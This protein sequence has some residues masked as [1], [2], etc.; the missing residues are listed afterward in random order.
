VLRTLL[1]C[2]LLQFIA[3]VTENCHFRLFTSLLQSLLIPNMQSTYGEIA[4]IVKRLILGLYEKVFS[5]MTSLCTCNS[6]TDFVH[7]L[8]LLSLFLK[9][10][11]SRLMR[12]PCCLCPY[13]YP[14]PSQQLL[15]SW[16][17]LNET[18]H[19][20]HGTW[21]HL[22]R[23]TSQIHS[24][25]NINIAASHNVELTLIL[26]D[27]LNRSLWNLECTSCY[28]RSSQWRTSQIHP[29]SK[30]NTADSHTK[31]LLAYDHPH[32]PKVHPFR[33]DNALATTLPFEI[34]LIHAQLRF[35]KNWVY[36]IVSQTYLCIHNK[37]LPHLSYQIL[38]L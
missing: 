11:K 23:H 35:H 10:N 6:W 4:M 15:N 21:A 7:N 37:V 9:H 30:T 29:F 5:G 34:A 31:P 18:W 1:I 22:K 28:P 14:P 13:V 36:I 32:L 8:S 26:I 33:T 20:Y 27:C 2:D 16:T 38:N 3:M 12:L 24:I 25:S 17:N 19:V